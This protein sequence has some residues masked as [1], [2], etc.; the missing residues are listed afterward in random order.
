MRSIDSKFYNRKAWH[1]VRDAYTLSVGG[2]CERCGQV[3]TY[4]HHR[5]HLNSN[6]VNDA[7]MAYS[8]D[9]LELLCYE[10]HNKEH[11][12]DAQATVDGIAFDEYGNVVDKTNRY[13]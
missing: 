3:G 11:F 8:H 6:N 5:T 12:G 13:E 2:M 9:N 1:V 4:V 7:Q 10:C